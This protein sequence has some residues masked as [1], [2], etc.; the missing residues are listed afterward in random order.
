MSNDDRKTKPASRTTRIELRATDEENEL[1]KRC[2]KHFSSVGLAGE[3]V[4]EFVRNLVVLYA[5]DHGLPLFEGDTPGSVGENE[6]KRRLA[7]KHDKIGE[8]MRRMRS[9][10]DI[11]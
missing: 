4:S 5:I 9:R 10:K 7:Q 3:E 1:F 6:D 8:G 2:A 11:P